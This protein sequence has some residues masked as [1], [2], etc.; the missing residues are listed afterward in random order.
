MQY[1]QSGTGW[2]Q[3]G[4]SADDYMRAEARYRARSG[5]AAWASHHGEYGP[6]YR[7]HSSRSRSSRG[8]WGGFT[9]GDGKWEAY[10]TGEFSVYPGKREERYMSNLQFFGL[11]G[12]IVSWI[13]PPLV[14]RFIR[15]RCRSSLEHS[16]N[17]GTMAT[18]QCRK[19]SARADSRTAASRVSRRPEERLDAS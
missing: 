13:I 12:A 1:L 17:M 8:A 11:I 7:Q 19:R 15:Q 9:G 3:S 10:D 18:I 6:R 16:L 14:S 5:A 2:D 4:M